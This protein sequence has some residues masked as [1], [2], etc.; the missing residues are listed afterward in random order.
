VVNT[1]P[2]LERALA[3]LSLQPNDVLIADSRIIPIRAFEKVPAAVL[4]NVVIFVRCE[5]GE[6]PA[7]AL[8]RMPR[9]EAAQI[10]KQICFP[11]K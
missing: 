4:G 6:S 11:L 1:V 7:S 2:R 5:P 9:E 8:S 10:L 3:K